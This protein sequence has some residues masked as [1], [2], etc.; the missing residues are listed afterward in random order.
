MADVTAQDVTRFWV[1]EVGPAGWYKADDA[2]DAQIR[3]RFLATWEAAHSGDM[4]EWCHDGA[5]VLGFL[6][7][8][9]QLPRN[10]FRGDP[11]SFATDVLARTAAK[12]AIH[13]R[14]DLSVPEPER[15][16]FYLPLMHSENLEDQDRCIRLMS[17]RL[18]ETGESNV[19]HARAHREIVRLFGRFPFRNEALGRMTLPKEQVFL[20]T[21][22]YGAVLNALT[23]EGEAEPSA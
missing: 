2:L 9:D 17:D 8:T 15:Q 7:L 14:W 20:D 10:M 3:D 23:E 11:R 16:F 6:I 18:P 21:G 13:R 1:E 12:L 5:G 4:Y 19:R 22:G